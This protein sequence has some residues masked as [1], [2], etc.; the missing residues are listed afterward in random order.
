MTRDGFEHIDDPTAA[1]VII[2]NTC[3]F[4]ESAVEE[5]VDAILALREENASAILVAAGCLPLRY[6][7][8]VLEP[9]PE[10]DLFVRPEQIDE[11]PD[12][13]R[14]TA[15]LPTKP[16][17]EAFDAQ[18]GRILT[19]PG[20]A[21]L[22]IAEGCSRRCA[23]CTIP[24]IRGP[25]CSVDPA[26]L[27]EE[28]RS[29]V[30]RGARELILVAQDI[31]AYGKDLRP[32]VTLLDVLRRLESVPGAQWIRLMYLHPGGV[33]EAL[34]RLIRDSEVILPYLDIPFQHVSTPVLEAMGRPVRGRD[35]RELVETLRKDCPGIVLRTTL[36]VGFPGEGEKEFVELCEFVESYAFERVGVFTYS[37]EENTR[38]F[39]LGDPIP[40]DVKQRR[41]REIMSIQRDHMT[42]RNRDRIGSVDECIVEGHS[43]ETDLLLQGRM[44]DQAPEVDG[45]L[46]ITAGTA[47]VGEIRR[48]RITASHHEDLFGELV[49]R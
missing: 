39:P 46:F 15:D 29:L 28:A 9:L 41:A 47:D 26:D 35:I 22:R 49:E 4:I 10:V 31:T 17:P 45:Q 37:P 34:P 19:T 27:E 18:T 40:E 6:G 3:A 8:E 42:R 32:T 36:M 5:S 21:Y 48:V 12:L 23:Y 11:L 20:Y 30:E 44:W 7:D 2:V 14:R 38:A 1:D 33:P 24:A 16:K 43:D 13:I 25:L